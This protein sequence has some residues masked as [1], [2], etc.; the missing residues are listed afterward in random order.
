MLH[1]Q[2]GASACGGA[3]TTR[4]HVVHRADD[5]VQLAHNY[6]I[7]YCLYTYVYIHIIYVPLGLLL[8][9][10]HGLVHMESPRAA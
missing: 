2:H 1:V 9:A 6:I 4:E 5:V 7:G 10:S 3:R 8:I